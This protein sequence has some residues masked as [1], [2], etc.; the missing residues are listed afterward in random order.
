MISEAS[1]AIC[2]FLGESCRGLGSFYENSIACMNAFCL[3]LLVIDPATASRQSYPILKKV[4][5][6]ATVTL[7]RTPPS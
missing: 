2:Q 6:L 3:G 4:N 5:I 7:L 1:Q